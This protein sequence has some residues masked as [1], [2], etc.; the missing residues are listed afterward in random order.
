MIHFTASSAPK[1][2]AALEHVLSVYKQTDLE[3][4][5]IVVAIGGDGH[6]L[7]V[8]HTTLGKNT[9]V[10]GMNR[11][12]VGFLLNEYRP[13]G[14]VERVKN[15]RAVTLEPLRMQVV[16]KDGKTHEAIAINEVS[17]LRQTRQTGKLRIVIDGIER[18]PCLICDGAILCTPAGSTAYNLSAYGPILPL[19]SRLLALTPI[20]PFRP[21]RWRGAL[22]PRDFDVV[23][24]VL[25]PEKRP[26]SAVAD[27]VEIRD[28]LR[29]KVAAAHDTTFTLL[30]DP[31]RSLDERI[32]KE[33]FT[34]DTGME[35]FGESGFDED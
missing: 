28:A 13:D 2:Q 14:I 25:E 29:I 17:L 33:Q 35:N 34:S 11:G 9:P 22:L 15:A 20:S 27:F 30:F 1:A 3:R 19:R 32:L 12:S 7:D 24:E 6:L 31:D 26:V 23:F 21:R 18:M 16:T 4:A 5:E 10:F 8:L